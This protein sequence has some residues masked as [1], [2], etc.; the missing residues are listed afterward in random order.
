MLAWILLFVLRVV[1][2]VPS[3]E[4][5]IAAS[6]FAFAVFVLAAYL[7][8]VVGAALGLG[9]V[10]GVRATF[11]SRHVVLPFAVLVVGML[12]GHFVW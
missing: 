7:V 3:R 5:L 9:I 1:G 6:G 12:F 4:T 11:L 10:I 2:V 8:D